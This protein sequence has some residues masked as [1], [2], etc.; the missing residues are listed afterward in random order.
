MLR[1]R[2]LCKLW[3]ELLNLSYVDEE[4]REDVAIAKLEQLIE[5]VVSIRTA[6][7]VSPDSEAQALYED[8]E[9]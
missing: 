8:F 7:I 2:K 9:L 5:L 1:G 4:Q 6:W 3:G